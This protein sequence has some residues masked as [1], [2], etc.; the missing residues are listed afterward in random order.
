[1]DAS[2]TAR[3]IEF[4]ARWWG[5]EPLAVAPAKSGFSGAVVLRVTT[6]TGSYACRLWPAGVVSAAQLAWIHTCQT[7]A[8]QSC[9]FVPKLMSTLTGATALIHE[10]RFVELADWMP[11]RADFHLHPSAERLRAAVA[12]LARLHHVWSAH[13]TVGPCPAAV[14]RY[15]RLAQWTSTREQL[16][17]TGLDRWP[18]D[19][20]ANV[21]FRAARLLSANR[22]NA[23]ARLQPWC[24]RPLP[25]QPC[26]ADI[27]HDHVLFIG[28]QVT[29]IVD[30]GATRWDYPAVDLARLLGSL[31]GFDT[32]AWAEALDSY[33][34]PLRTAEP[35]AYFELPRLLHWTG[36][37]AALVTWLQQLVLAP[38][39][40]PDP[41]RAWQRFE[42]L[43]NQL[44]KHSGEWEK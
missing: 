43:T 10:N 16:L 25:L 14:R 7:Q 29:G 37:L 3:L 4:V 24:R 33:N 9:R 31:L 18:S 39:P 12:A 34:G 8:A 21:A 30:F 20:Q 40:F 17:Q 44:A 27:W 2:L 28:D 19:E 32:V 42:D 6:G 13:R 38:G 5:L 1:M 41:E 36:Q 26:L 11:G 15:Q 35:H 23:L 22:A